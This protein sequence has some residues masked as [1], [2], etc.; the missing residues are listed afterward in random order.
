MHAEICL[1]FIN[2]KI[3]QLDSNNLFVIF[4]L[5]SSAVKNRMHA[6]VCP[7]FT[8]TVRKCFR[9]VT[10]AIHIE[11]L[12]INIFYIHLIETLV[13]SVFTTKTRDENSERH[14]ISNGTRIKFT[15][16]T[17]WIFSQH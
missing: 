12:L 10:V 9:I 14:F 6:R 16:H 11:I 4:E 17:A 7:V 3:I 8:R 5:D 15:L 2:L 1:M 13:I